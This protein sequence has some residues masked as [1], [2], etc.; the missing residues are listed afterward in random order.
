M[1]PDR[2]IGAPLVDRYARA[3]MLTAPKLASEPH[4]GTLDGYWLNATQFFFLQERTHTESGHIVRVPCRFDARSQGVEEVISLDDVRQAVSQ[5]TGEVIDSSELADATFDFPRPNVLAMSIGERDY[6]LDA[7]RRS[8]LRVAHGLN[9]PALYSPDG[10]HACFLK[11]DNLWVRNRGSSLERPLSTNGEIHNAYAQ[12]CGA[13][14]TSS[15]GRGR[16]TPLGL[17]SPESTWFLTHQVDER[18]VPDTVLV[19]HCPEGGGRPR[20]HDFKYA[21]PGDPVPSGT[22]VAF[23]MASGKTARFPDSAFAGGALSPFEFKRV[24]FS[25]DQ[26]AWM[27]RLDRFCKQVDLVALDLAGGTSRI[28]LSERVSAGYID[29]NSHVLAAPNVRTLTQTKEVIWYSERDGWGHL[30]LFDSAT[31]QL[32]N[33][34]TTGEF[35]VRNIVHVDHERRR[36][37]LLVGGLEP[38]SDPSHRALC[39][40]NF[41]GSGFDVLL[42]HDGDIS[43]AAQSPCGLAQDRP[44]RPTGAPQVVSPDG[45]F[46][47]VYRRSVETGNCT[48]LLNIPTRDR[49]TIVCSKRSGQQTNQRRIVSLAADGATPLHGVMFLP[50]DFDDRRSYPLIDYI[51]PGPQVVQQPQSYRSLAAAPA[52]ALAELGFVT[53]MLDTRGMPHRSRAFHQ[54]GYGALLEPQLSDHAAVVGNLCNTYSFLDRERVGIFGQSAGGAAAV[55]ALCDYGEVFKVGVAACGNYNPDHYSSHW[56]DKYRGEGESAGWRADS[57]CSVAHKLRGPLLIISGDMD[58]NVPMSQTFCLANELISA[59]CDFDLVIIPNQGHEVLLTSGYA[60]RR[61]WDFFIRHLL[62]KIPPNRFEIAYSGYELD[63]YAKC[64]RDEDGQ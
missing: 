15:L 7:S 9:V 64:S 60:Q 32:K 33:R 35:V 2:T 5:H 3:T 29:L 42:A 46:A 30:Y 49:M 19:Q 39:A 52:M 21:I 6:L 43:T 56:S 51:Y 28:V 59:N 1:T 17:W 55:R 50:S 20:V 44:F 16:P 47:I 61:M 25:N 12:W 57:V 45:R 13:K 48:D 34:I 38:A 53:L 23:H 14:L 37:L 62:Q 27:L 31:G 24:W 4:V 8:L 22:L 41:D 58:E 63:R 10:Q 18:R 36:L 54:A 40:V 11:G 26:T